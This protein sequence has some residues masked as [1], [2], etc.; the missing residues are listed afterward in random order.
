MNDIFF[1]FLK[2]TNNTTH[3]YIYLYIQFVTKGT[4]LSIYST[5]VVIFTRSVFELSIYIHIH[6]YIYKAPIYNT[7]RQQMHIVPVPVKQI[8]TTGLYRLL[9]LHVLKIYGKVP[10]FQDRCRYS[11]TGADIPRQNIGLLFLIFYESV[12]S[13]FF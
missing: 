2:R 10:I 8:Q 7:R 11:K 5:I 6:I 12:C 3:T 1:N 13:F 4:Y 9:T